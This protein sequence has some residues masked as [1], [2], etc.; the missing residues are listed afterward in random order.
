MNVLNSL[1]FSMASVKLM[2]DDVVSS[3]PE[4]DGVPL[5]N[6][7]Y[8]LD[9][10]GNIVTRR[11]PCE[12]RSHSAEGD[13]DRFICFLRS[14]L[15]MKYEYI[16]NEYKVP[17]IYLPMVGPKD[18]L[19]FSIKRCIFIVNITSETELGSHPGVL[20]VGGGAA[21]PGICKPFPLVSVAEEW[22]QFPINES[23][24]LTCSATVGT[25]IPWHCHD[26][27]AHANMPHT[28]KDNLALIL[29]IAR[30]RIEECRERNDWLLGSLA[31]ILGANASYPEHT[32]SKV[33]GTADMHYTNLPSFFEYTETNFVK[34]KIRGLFIWVGSTNRRDITD[35]QILTLMN[36]T[37]EGTD[38]DVGWIATEDQ[39]PCRIGTTVCE[40]VNQY[41]AYHTGMPV[42]RMNFAPAAW[43]C[44]QRRPIRALAHTLTLFDPEFV[45]IGDDD[46]YINYPLLAEKFLTFVTR[47]IDD[48]VIG[49]LTM[50]K[51]VTFRGF[52]Q[53]G[54][55]Y[56]FGRKSVIALTS[57]SIKAAPEK[58]RSNHRGGYLHEYQ[59]QQLSIARDA[60]DISNATKCADCAYYSGPAMETSIGVRLID[61]CNNLMASERTCYHSDHSMSRCL[62]H[63]S[64]SVPVHADCWGGFTPPNDSSHGLKIKM[65]MIVAVCDVKMHL[66]CHRWFPRLDDGTNVEMIF[67]DKPDYYYNKAEWWVQPP[68]GTSQ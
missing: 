59:I 64:Y 6:A 3:I 63:G 1:G 26:F 41:L 54:A 34:R 8:D 66:T 32:G 53:G 55:G 5:I 15:S 10:N 57:F 20:G 28:D 11:C 35:R 37:Y 27:V 50:G 36:A 24:P 60:V 40:E 43:S 25:I 49:Q 68:N 16:M 12:R 51:K 7:Q 33:L 39:H 46:T 31:N 17:F 65:C 52:F 38:A 62:I 22:L 44:G 13:K 45:F 9:E 29:G 2:G 47:D 61:I 4:G 56:L 30:R 42:T 14:P 18:L 67:H 48:L 23:K 19:Q 21:C 58:S